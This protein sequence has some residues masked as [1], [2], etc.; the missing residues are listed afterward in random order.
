MKWQ[1]IYSCGLKSAPYITRKTLNLDLY[2]EGCLKKC[3]LAFIKKYDMPTIFWPNLA[4]IRYSKKSL[5]WYEQNGVELVPM[6]ANPPNFPEQQ[7][8]KSHWSI[9]KGILLKS[10]KL[11]SDKKALKKKLKTRSGDDAKYSQ[12]YLVFI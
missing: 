6:D 7:V 3:P 2:M 1:A 9:I 5:E 4:T 11:A 12:K 8:I 10:K